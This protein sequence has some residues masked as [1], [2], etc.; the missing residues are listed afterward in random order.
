[1]KRTTG[2]PPSPNGASSFHLWWEPEPPLDTVE[3]SVDLT[4]PEY[5][6]HQR[7]VFWALQ[8]EFTDGSRRHGGAHV[9]L[10]WNARHP[11]S[12]AVNWGG[13][14]RSGRVLD[15]SESPL[16]SSPSDPNT[17]DYPWTAGGP[18]RL[19]V[20]PGSRPGWWMASVTDPAGSEQVIRELHA[21]GHSLARPVVWSEVFADCDDPS[22]S[23]VWSDPVCAGG[24]RRWAPSGYRAT[25]QEERNGGCSNTDVRPVAGGVA[26]VTSVERH[27]RPG[28]IVPIAGQDG[29]AFDR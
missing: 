19:R 28:S 29:P 11:G 12:R 2:R 13:Y 26:Q 4:I 14:D 6:G 7:L 9:G 8:V 15:G 5:P 3:V 25:F 20:A 16:V 18:H 1:M 24:S 23:A 27:T 17:R 10:Q 22:V 21:G